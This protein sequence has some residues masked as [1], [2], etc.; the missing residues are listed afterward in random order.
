MKET[1]SLKVEKAFLDESV[2]YIITEDGIPI[3]EI[4]RW[5]DIQSYN[6]YLTGQKYAYALVKY[7]NFLKSYKIHYKEVHDKKVIESYIKH[8]MY[9]DDKIS[10]F[11]GKLSFNAIKTNIS[12]IKGFYEWLEDNGEI[13]TNPVVYGK[14]RGNNQRQKL[15]SKFL[16]GQI[17]DFDIEKSIGSKLTYKRKQEHHK[18]YTEEEIKGILKHL[19]TLRD[20]IIY[21]ISVEHGARIGEILGLKLEDFDSFESKLSIRRNSNIENEA[22]VKTNERDL[23]ISQVLSDEIQFYLR[24]ERIESDVDF[25]DFIFL[26]HKGKYKGKPLRRRNYLQILKSAA[27]KTGL[28][29]SK[30]RTHS[31]RSTRAQE[32]VELSMEQPELGIN[33]TFILE[34]MGWR[35]IDTLQHYKKAFTEKNRV[36]LLNKI[37]EAKNKTRSDDN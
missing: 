2:R 21:R 8:L 32:L 9:G 13:E 16:Y 6:S 23:F 12:I 34:E 29:P 35:S 1:S 20:R 30:I 36:K 28:D 15:N 4:S 7:L 22:L 19:P 24:G 5:L 26:N 27:K 17:W 11:E 10:G 25:S 37:S 33:D 31:G 14:K 3:L 18:W